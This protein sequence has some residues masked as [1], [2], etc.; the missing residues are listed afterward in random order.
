[1]GEKA[2]MQASQRWQVERTHAWENAFHRLACCYER[3]ATVI[4]TFSTSPI[5]SLSSVV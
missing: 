2:P 5:R 1:M 3:R 4:D